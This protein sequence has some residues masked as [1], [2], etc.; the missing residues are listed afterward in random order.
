MEGMIQQALETNLLK[1]AQTMEDQI[2]AQLHQLDNLEEDDIERVRH[3]RIDEMKR[4]E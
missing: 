1:A 3:R 2:D 4:Y